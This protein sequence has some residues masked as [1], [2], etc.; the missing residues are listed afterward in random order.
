MLEVTRLTH[1]KLSVKLPVGRSSIGKR[2]FARERPADLT[3]HRVHPKAAPRTTRH[4]AAARAA[5][6]SNHS[7]TNGKSRTSRM[8]LFRLAISCGIA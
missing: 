7:P 1:R 3:G 6:P 2:D 4:R 8:R 5:C